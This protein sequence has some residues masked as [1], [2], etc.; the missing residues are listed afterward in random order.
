MHAIICI[1]DFMNFLLFITKFIKLRPITKF[2]KSE[3]NNR[4]SYCGCWAQVQSHR[5]RPSGDQSSCRLSATSHGCGV[6]EYAGGSRS[7]VRRPTTVGCVFHDDRQQ[8][9]RRLSDGTHHSR[10]SSATTRLSHARPTQCKYTTVFHHKRR[11]HTHGHMSGL[12][13]FSKF[14]TV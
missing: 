10:V 3:L 4:D 6:R 1:S 2:K 11:H 5:G 13:R 9:Q 12:N 8:R 7:Q 14:F